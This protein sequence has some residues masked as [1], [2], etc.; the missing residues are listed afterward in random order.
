MINKFRKITLLS[1][2]ILPNFTLGQVDTTLTNDRIEILLEE[3]S[4]DV[5][6]SQLY[7][8]IEQLQ[9]NPVDINFADVDELLQ[10]PFLDF[11][12]A[13]AIVDHRNKYGKYFSTNELND[14]KELT[15]V[16]ANLIKIFFTT[17]SLQR[18][19]IETGGVFQL[20]V[21]LE[22]RTRAITDLQQREGF[23]DGSYLGSR[24]KNYNRLKLNYGNNITAGFLVEKDAGEDSFTDFYSFHVQYKRGNYKIIGGDYL[25]EFGQGLA[26][27]GPYGFSKGG[28]AISPINKKAR[29]IIAYT[30]SDENQ[31]LRGGAAQI[32]IDKFRI[33]P[34]VSFNDIDASVDNHSNQITSLKTDG[35]HRTESEESRKNTVDKQVF[36]SIVNYKPIKNIDLGLLFYNT[37]FSHSLAN[38]GIRFPHGENFNFYS[39]S[40]S[41][42]Y[43]NIFVSG[44]FAYNDV[45]VAS[46]NN[47]QISLTDKISFITSIRSYPFNFFNFHS[48]G[49]GERSKTQNEF[50]V[51]AGLRWR[52]DFGLFNLYYDQF[53]FRD[54]F[55][56]FNVG[57]NEFLINYENNI[58][59][60]TRLLLRF[61]REKKEVDI[62][63]DMP[64]YFDQIRNKFRGE[65]IYNPSKYIRLKS[66]IEF[67][68][69]DIDQVK[70]ESGFLTFQDIRYDISNKVRFYGRVIFFKTD[71]FDSRIYEFENDL[72]GV[73]TNPALFGEGMRWYFVVNYSILT[74]LKLSLKYSEL[75]KPEERIL[76]SG[77]NEIEGNLDNRISFQLDY[78]LE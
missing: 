40:Y 8:L 45:S 15:K 29:G 58:F 22:F 64:E 61:Q 30:S 75:V 2:I 14:I 51:Y 34:F 28:N 39:F 27:W 23:K 21:E 73:I 9:N 24:I 5:D 26:L 60:R 20:P 53:T 66:R 47:V 41:S 62:S 54:N 10:V 3:S 77:N 33:I 76:S 50:G 44:E 69:L 70:N 68:W 4:I 18:K 55:S 72:T 65:L 36:G 63:F 11:K 1:L 12:E 56:Q 52:S 67:I 13:K 46:I 48:N 16:K 31:F 57:G 49:F 7:D 6:D 35:L 37:N 38:K 32:K 42:F 43:K 17:R 25:V 78:T 59:S 19:E 71:S 74:Y